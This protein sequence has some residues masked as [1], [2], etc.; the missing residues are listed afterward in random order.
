MAFEVT[1]ERNVFSES[2]LSLSVG[3]SSTCIA[4]LYQLRAQDQDAV[5]DFCTLIPLGTLRMV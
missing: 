2:A 5:G 1:D 3:L 4:V